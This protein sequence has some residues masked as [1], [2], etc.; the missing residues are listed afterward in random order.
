[1]KGLMLMSWLNELNR[2]YRTSRYVYPNRRFH[3]DDSRDCCINFETADPDAIIL[4]FEKMVNHR[5]ES[6]GKDHPP[7]CDLLALQGTESRVDVVLVEVKAGT[8]AYPPP[9]M[10]SALLKAMRQLRKSVCI[11]QRELDDCEIGLPNEVNRQAVVVMRTPGQRQIRRDVFSA[12]IAEFRVHTGFR[13]QIALCGEDIGRL[14]G[15]G[16]A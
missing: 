3:H 8:A 14:A 11:I 9:C 2:Y 15:L 6:E 13:L 1:M 5:A 4:D 7:K 10:E 16:T 12:A